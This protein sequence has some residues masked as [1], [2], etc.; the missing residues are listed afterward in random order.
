MTEPY[1]TSVLIFIEVIFSLMVLNTL[2]KA[3]GNNTLLV[4]LGGIFILWIITAYMMLSAGFF[5][6]TGV[7]QLAFTV[8]VV[9]PIVLGL[10]AYKFSNPLAVAINNIPTSSFLAL[11]QMRA[12]FG[13]IFFFALS[14]PGWF[15]YIGGLG[16]IAAGIGAFLA[17]RYLQKHPEMETQAI[18]K[19]NLIGILDFIIVLNLGVGVVLQAQSPDIMFDLIPL[20]VVPIFIL[21]HIFSLLKLRTL[22]R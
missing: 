21:L 3:G 7:P 16:D 8:G 20:Y 13:V 17:L 15:Q 9:V 10:L 6:A 19:G 18:V 11:Q 22:K 12:A 1:F 5:S 14:L 2:K 4:S